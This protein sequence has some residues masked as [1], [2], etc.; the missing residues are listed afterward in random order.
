M[1]DEA[2]SF[3]LHVI[4]KEGLKLKPEQLQAVRHIYDGKDLPTGFGKS[5]CYE[6]LPFV[7]DHKEQ[8]S[9]SCTSA[10]SSAVLV[11]SPLMSLIIDQ[12]ESLR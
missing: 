11:V 5:A 1:F 6:R 12:V 10:N 8:S 9:T 4:G 2:V 7:F 3:A